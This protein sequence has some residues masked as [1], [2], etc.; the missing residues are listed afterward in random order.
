MRDE[1]TEDLKALIDQQI[2]E[3]IGN[4]REHLGLPRDRLTEGEKERLKY[5]PECHRAWDEEDDA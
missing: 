5:C 2:K 4:F 3:A 1:R